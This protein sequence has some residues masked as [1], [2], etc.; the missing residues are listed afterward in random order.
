M[1]VKGEGAMTRPE[2]L[3]EEGTPQQGSDDQPVDF[4]T[5]REDARGSA[6]ITWGGPQSHDVL[7]TQSKAGESSRE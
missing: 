1:I 3:E 7:L 2:L 6:A 4:E 5:R